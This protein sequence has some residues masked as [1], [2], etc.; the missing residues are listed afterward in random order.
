MF[1]L[2]SALVNNSNRNIFLTGK[3]GTGK[4]TFLRHIKQSCVKQ[5]A[6]VAPTG[7]AAINAGG[8]TIHSF[9][10]LPFSPFIPETKGFVQPNSINNR[11]AYLSRLR[12][13]SDKIKIF[14]QLELL[15]IDEISMVRCDMLDAVDA[16]LKHYRKRHHEP[17][18]GVQ[19][20][21]IGDLFQL[22]PVSG[23]N[24]W[25]LLSEYYDSPYFFSSHVFRNS[26]ALYIEFQKI[27]RQQ[28]DQF[29]QL[30]N[31]VRNNN[32][33][34]SD[35]T[36][37][38]SLVHSNIKVNS[39][40][41]VLTTHNF[42]ADEIN[43]KALQALKGK[44]Y[45]FRAKIE[46]EFSEKA[47]PADEKLELKLGAQVM[48][49]KNDTEKVKRYFNGKIGVVKRIEDEEIYVQ[50]E[51]DD[52]E[53]KV[54]LETW[55]NLRYSLNKNSQQLEEEKLGSFTQ[56]PLR[57]AWA[58]T[59]HKSQGL[60][61][62]N[63]VIDAGAAFAP[64][65]VYVA[66]SRCISL[67]GLQLTTP[68]NTTGLRTDNRIIEFSNQQASSE[69]LQ[70]ELKRSKKAYEYNLLVE[71]FSV[72]AAINLCDDL[73]SFMKENE[74]SFNTEALVWVNE[75]LNWLQS[76]QRTSENFHKHLEILI[77]K[78]EYSENNIEL[79]ERISS[80]SSYFFNQINDYLQRLNAS[81]AVT[82]SR[83]AAKTYNDSLRDIHLTLSLKKH[84]LN[85]QDKKFSIEQYHSRKKDFVA[86]YFSV[87]AYATSAAENKESKH[88]NLQ[89]QLRQLRNK[90]CEQSNT[91]IYMV[92]SGKTIEEMVEF[93]PQTKTDLLK[94]S[95]F[96]KAKVEAYGERFLEIITNYCNA[97]NL[98]TTIGIKEEKKERK[99]KKP[100]TETKTSTKDLSY[101]LFTEGK[102]IQ[103]IAQER[104][105][106]ISTI[107]GHMASFIEKGII[108]I[109]KLMPEER[110]NKI[111][112]Q[113]NS[114]DNTLSAAK[115]KL[116]S[117]VT[118]GEIRLVMAYKKFK[119]GV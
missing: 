75:I 8:T 40:S 119:A 81:P 59:V 106:A 64:G 88:P 21:M 42:K 89:M 53:I 28:D 54:P 37:L 66:L 104:N 76:L 1:H 65:Q 83:I 19:I 97:N 2:A 27:Y 20:L 18:G 32:L 108:D 71:L 3:A 79:H 10:Q 44:T 110:L 94:I 109:T 51:N 11:N 39:G 24:E 34:P 101:V 90:I 63:A 115:Q 26:P 92:A 111:Y 13:N 38:N 69:F 70:E 116:S 98:H 23:N 55:D 67:Q 77:A 114:E 85:F 107:E 117:D 86:P 45:S 25:D 46:N 31:N 60:T 100:K 95:G 29:I 50:C 35:Y 72:K 105:L 49:I 7:V 52:E 17:F 58:I 74:K 61:F 14:Q 103:Q 30:L 15:I 112:P 56:Y 16:V 36:L 12:V 87:N 5:T 78:T 80:A 33:N 6:V 43:K 62:K 68:V 9:F 47:Y 84:L 118:F 48:F 73:I 113:L 99:E 82:D 4:T 96:G 91:P 41:I 93:L 102:T 57:L 22:P